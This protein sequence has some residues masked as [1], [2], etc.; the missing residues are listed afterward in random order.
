MECRLDDW[1]TDDGRKTAQIKMR[2][3]VDVGG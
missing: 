1:M 2:K 3:R